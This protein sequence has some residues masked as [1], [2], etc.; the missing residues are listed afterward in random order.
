MHAPS[1]SSQR[2]TTVRHGAAE[3]VAICGLS[4]GVAMVTLS[5]SAGNG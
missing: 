5:L 3:R 2:A 1:C 4:G